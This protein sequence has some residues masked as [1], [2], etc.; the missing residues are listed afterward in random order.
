MERRS[1]AIKC[2]KQKQCE[3]KE[4]E[5]SLINMLQDL[6]NNICNSDRLDTSLLIYM[7]KVNGFQANYDKDPS[8]FRD[9]LDMPQLNDEEQESLDQ[10]ISR[11]QLYQVIKSFAE[12]KTPGEDGFTKEFYV[13]FFNLFWVCSFRNITKP[14][15]RV[16]FLS[17][18]EGEYIITLIPKKRYQFN[19]INQLETHISTKC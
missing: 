15:E 9:G 13:T 18:K 7:S 8:N 17:L 5:I 14:L 11:E 12:N 2:S 4:I 1:K 19:R 6:H 16:P 3:L 10:E